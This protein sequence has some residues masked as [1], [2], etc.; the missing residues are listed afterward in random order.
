MLR[1][2]V[3]LIP[4][5]DESLKRTLRTLTIINVGKSPSPEIG[6]YRVEFRNDNGRIYKKSRVHNHRRKALGPWSLVLK[7]I[8]T[9]DAPSE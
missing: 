7:A 2:T 9:L 1:I 3:D 6:N 5:G 4:F 8:Q